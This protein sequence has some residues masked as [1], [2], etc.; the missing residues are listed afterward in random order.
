MCKLCFQTYF[1]CKVLIIVSLWTSDQYLEH[2]Q[3][4]RMN[5]AQ[6]LLSQ[7]G[8]WSSCCL[9]IE[10]FTLL[11][12]IWHLE[13]SYET[14]NSLFRDFWI[15]FW[16]DKALHLVVRGQSSSVSPNSS[17]CRP[18]GMT[19]EGCSRRQSKVLTAKSKAQS[20]GQCSSTALA[21][22]TSKQQHQVF[23]SP[24]QLLLAATWAATGSHRKICCLSCYIDLVWGKSAAS[25]A[26]LTQFGSQKVLMVHCLQI[27]AVMMI[28][29]F[30]LEKNIWWI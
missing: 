25:F 6:A 19:L 15:K 3:G 20:L 11:A 21:G 28:V 5:E 16:G 24:W 29:F 18:P 12:S 4:S 7:W 2:W 9:N 14:T 27:W 26:M 17:P 8:H 10:N 13:W 1:Q 22:Q 23:P 30:L